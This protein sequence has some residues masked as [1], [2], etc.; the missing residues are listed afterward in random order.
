MKNKELEKYFKVLEY[1]EVFYF[2][3]WP[4]PKV[5]KIAVGVYTIWLDTR[6]I[7]VGMAGRS[8]TV[9]DIA[10]HRQSTS[11]RIRG[12]YSRLNSHAGGRRSG[13]QFCVYV[14]DRLVLPTLSKEEIEQISIGNLSLD[15]LAKRYIHA[16]LSYRFVEVP[17]SE[18]A[19]LVENAIRSG[20]LN[21]SKPLLNPK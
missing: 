14:A 2:R 6:L 10:N 18:Q 9:E 20:V 17:D 15:N 21:C 12:L 11:I 3:N 13:D 16:N 8:L 5:P 4:N 1:E 7:Y 19:F